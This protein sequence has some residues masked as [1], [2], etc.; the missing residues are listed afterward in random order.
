MKTVRLLIGG[1]GNAAYPM[2]K[3]LETE[4]AELRQQ[5]V[6]FD[7]NIR[8][9]M[10]V[11]TPAAAVDAER[12]AGNVD[13][14]SIGTNDLTQYLF[15]ADRTNG[16]VSRLNSHFQ[17]TLLRCVDKIVR[18]AHSAGIEVDICGHAGEVPELVPLWVG[19]EVDALSVSIPMIAK[20]RQMVCCANQKDC[21]KLVEEILQEEEEYVVRK[22]LAGGGQ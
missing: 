8:V 9:G 22:R 16:R 13:F 3:L 18:S 15:A 19:M 5:H 4:K 11:E 2:V 1:L 7:E 12:F 6:N 10:M 21:K 17:P 14:F 20:V